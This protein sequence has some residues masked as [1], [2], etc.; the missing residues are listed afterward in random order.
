M[1]PAGF[2]ERWPLP[3]AAGARLGPL[4]HRLQDLRPRAKSH[5]GDQGPAD[6]QVRWGGGRGYHLLASGG[7]QAAEFRLP[8]R[9]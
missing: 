1:Q 4:Q 9:P 7:R 8:Q 2:H 3:C 5:G 6:R